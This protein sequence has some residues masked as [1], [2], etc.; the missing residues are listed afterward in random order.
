MQVLSKS[1][2][3]IYL[4]Y[5][6]SERLEVGQTIK[7]YDKKEDRGLLLQ[8][9]ELN[10]VDLP[11]ILEDIVRHEAVV[12]RIKVNEVSSPEV[13][14]LITDIRDMKVARSKIRYEIRSGKIVPWSGWAPSRSS[15]ISSIRLADLIDSLSIKGRR[16]IVIGSSFIDNSEF[17]INA[18]D[19]QG[20]SIITGKKG[21]GKSHLAKSLLLG[22]IDYGAQAVVFD[23]NDEYSNLRYK[24]DGSRSPYYDKIITLEPNPL[25]G[26]EYKPLKFTL[27]YIGLDVFYTVMVDV[28]KLPD[29]SATTLRYIWD[30]LSKANL[31]T[32]KGLFNETDKQSSRVRE[33]LY[34][35]L[36]AVEETN[37]ITKNE[38]E[39]TKIE[40]YLDRISSGGALVI[41]LKAKSRVSQGIVVQTVISKIRQMLESKNSRPLFIFAEEAHLYL[42]RTAWIDLVT[43]MRHLGAYQFYI[44]NTPT[45]IDELIIRQTDNIFIFNLTNK[46]DIEH[47]LPATKIDSD[48]IESI[49]PS[50][51]PRRFL[52]IGEVTRGYP[53]LVNTRE[54]EY[55]TSGKT[56]LLWEDR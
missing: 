40:D 6:P 50:L 41:C 3:E 25:E 33:A 21:T 27:P 39:E 31:L 43:R 32:L 56:R 38:S 24:G 35:R 53:F 48:T 30:K 52:A 12:S 22:L 49:A 54:L 8:V 29:A 44:T 16:N 9:I 37:I 20:I 5:H 19:L 26:S 55:Q 2:D 23:I 17:T 47:I 4:I 45:S 13:K 15:E 11:G 18:Y 34:R 51:P 46:K 42:D 36:K 28:L 14:R 7:V 1:G 10:L